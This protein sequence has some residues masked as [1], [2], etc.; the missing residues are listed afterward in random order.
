MIEVVDARDLDVAADYGQPGE[1]RHRGRHRPRPLGD[2]VMAGE[3]DVGVLASR[4]SPGW[5]G[6]AWA[7]LPALERAR[8]GARLAV[9]DPEDDPEGVDRGQQRADV[10]A[11]D[12]DPEGAAALGREAED[13][14]LGEEAGGAR[15]GGQREGADRSSART[16]DGSARRK[17]RIRSMSW[18]P[19][20]AEI[21]EPAPMNSSALKNAWLMR[22]NIPAA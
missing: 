20:I 18:I 22:W 10:A 5:T 19:A 11:D 21:T 2:P 14:V 16:S 17:P 15:E 7:L 3:A 6:S 9:E 1:H 13:L 8:L 12:D 4:R